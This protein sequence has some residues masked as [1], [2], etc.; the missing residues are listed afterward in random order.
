MC[1]FLGGLI[2]D[3][4]RALQLDRQ[5]KRQRRSPTVWPKIYRSILSFSSG[6]SNLLYE[7]ENELNLIFAQL[8]RYKKF[9]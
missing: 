7:N 6:T 9:N 4:R 2:P 8:L 5:R 1:Q 3:R